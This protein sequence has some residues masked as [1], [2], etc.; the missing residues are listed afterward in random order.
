LRGYTVNEKRLR[1][2]GFAEAEQAIA[3]FS[4]TLK[5]QFLVTAEGRVLEVVQHYTRTWR[6]R[7]T[8]ALFPT[9]KQRQING[10]SKFRN[11]E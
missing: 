5:N 4:S 11:M 1:E 8:A 10:Y 3:L 6:W 9:C 2:R 7:L